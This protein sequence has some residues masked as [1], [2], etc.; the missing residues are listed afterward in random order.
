[1]KL[2]NF[3]IKPTLE[4]PLMIILNCLLAILISLYIYNIFFKRSLF[5]YI[6]DLLELNMILVKLRQYIIDSS[7]HVTSGCLISDGLIPSIID[8]VEMSIE[9]IRYLLGSSSSDLFFQLKKLLH[10]ISNYS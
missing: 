5:N 2:F 4:T 8:G 1:M 10:F 3:N 9:T 6:Q 7:L